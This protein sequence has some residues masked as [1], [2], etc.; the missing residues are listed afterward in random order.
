MEIFNLFHGELDMGPEGDEPPGYE[1]VRAVRVG[2]KIGASRIGLSVYELPPGQSV[3]P[4]HL[5]WTDE[6]WLIVLG[7]TP[8]LRTPEGE[9]ALEAGDTVCFPAGP[10]GAH[11]VQNKADEPARVA[12]LS[13]KGP[14]GIAEYP[15]SDKIGVWA[16]GT[17]YMLKR[18]D[19]LDYWDGER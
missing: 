14:I 8:T 1:Q 9:R 4:Y 19:T 10:D 11:Q 7:G 2:N 6:E 3:C 12:L 13:T 18:S 5:E 15:D 16:N 17:H